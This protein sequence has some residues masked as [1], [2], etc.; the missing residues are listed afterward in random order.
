VG[1]NIG[2]DDCE[3]P[4]N[5]IAW[6][7]VRQPVVLEDWPVVATVGGARFTTIGSWRGS[8][9]PITAG[10]RTYGQKVHE[11]RKFASMP[12]LVN[13]QFEIALDIHP[14]EMK[15]LRLLRESHWHLVDPHRVAGDPIAFR[16]Y[17]QEST[18]E[19]SVAQGMYVETNSGWFSD[20]TVRYLASGKPAL[21]QDA[22]FSR[23]LPVGEGL[24]SFRTLHEAISGAE[25]ILRDYERHA[26]A[27]RIIAAE[28]FDSD[29]VLR[30]LLA[31]VNVALPPERASS[32][33]QFAV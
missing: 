6:R 23:N 12:R 20:R 15:D 13:S 5:G 9:G 10:D 17:I 16:R 27:A 21:V 32:S 4:T 28:Y 30:A 24:L 33:K 7:P 2:A 3:I 25:S 29:R 19:F 18:A 1:E 8:F 31:E 14:T 26:R 22:G 11:F